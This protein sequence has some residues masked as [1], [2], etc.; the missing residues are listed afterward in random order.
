MH[1]INKPQLAGFDYRFS[2]LLLKTTVM[3][4]SSGSGAI[5]KRVRRRGATILN[6]DEGQRQL[7]SPGF[8]VQ[9]DGKR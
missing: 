7:T 9:L 5:V 8:E 1:R 3:V 2:A 6:V 4:D